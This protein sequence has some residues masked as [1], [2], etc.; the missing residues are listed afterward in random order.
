LQ[1]KKNI[2]FASDL[3]LGMHPAEMSR[4]RELWFIQWLEEIRKDAAELWLLGDVFDYWFEYRKVIPKGYTRFLGK[5]AQMSDEG[6]KIH[7]FTGNHDVWIFDYLPEE[8]GLEV[9]R[10]PVVRQWAGQKFILGHGDGLIRADRAYRFLQRLFRSGT[11]QWLY[12][13]IH[14]NGSAAFAQWWSRKSRMKKGG[15]VPFLG[16]E[17]EH[18]VNYAKRAL[19]KDPEINYFLFGHRHIPFIVNLSEQSQ[20]VCLGDWISNFTF[21]ILEGENFQL[22]RY[23]KDKGEI[24]RL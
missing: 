9:H 14:P 3:H 19:K 24:I 18:Q 12:A 5:L 2:Y 8:I 7:L 17:K 20:V 21:G 11:L 6:I 23:F 1:E 22:K 13:R 4:Q 16:V 10:N 15:F